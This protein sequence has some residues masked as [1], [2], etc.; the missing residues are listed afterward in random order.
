[1]QVVVKL[2]QRDLQPLSGRTPE[3]ARADLREAVQAF[4]G[5]RISLAAERDTYVAGASGQLRARLYCPSPDDGG[6]PAPLVVYY[7]GG[8]WVAGDLDTHDQ[9]CRLLAKSSGARVLS[10]DYRLA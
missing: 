3:E 4:E 9:P 1:M 8:G 6:P 5:T 2:A 10:V 7:H